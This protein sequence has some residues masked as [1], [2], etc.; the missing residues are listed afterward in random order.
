MVKGFFPFH[1]TRQWVKKDKH[2]GFFQ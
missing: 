2:A 1:I